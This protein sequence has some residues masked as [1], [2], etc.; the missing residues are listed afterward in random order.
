VLKLECTEI[1][2]PLAGRIDRRRVS[3]GNLVQADTTVLTTIVSLDPIDFYFDIDERALLAYARDARERGGALQRG[4]ASLPVTVRLADTVSDTF[5]GTLNFAENRVDG[6]SGT[7]R[8]RAR[9]A[10]DGLIMQPGMFGRV[11]V[12]ASLPY[13][14][15]LVPDEAVASDQNRRV[16][17]VLGEG[18][19]VS[20]TPVRPGPRIY[21]YR[22]IR[23]GLSGD[24][25]IV[26][27]GLARIRPGAVV[28]PER[29]DLPLTAAAA[30]EG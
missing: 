7:I 19:A 29:V 4:A 17:Y 25:T 14:G 6:E 26:I 27:N 18:N 8:L 16:V 1:R 10:N 30:S 3:A 21:G 2:A 28:D 12:P 24:E 22:V 11:N 15:V 13:E 23:E 5:S 9:F 20:V